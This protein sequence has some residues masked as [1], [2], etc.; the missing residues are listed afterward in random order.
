LTFKEFIIKLII[1][2]ITLSSIQH[3]LNNL[4]PLF[5][6]L[7]EQSFTTFCPSAHQ[8]AKACSMSTL[9]F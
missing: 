6:R 3:I 4:A 5:T 9:I 2:N 1:P 7:A 8:A